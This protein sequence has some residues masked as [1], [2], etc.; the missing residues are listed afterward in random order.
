MAKKPDMNKKCGFCG[1]DG[2][3][4]KQAG[5]YGEW[6]LVDADEKVHECDNPIKRRY[7]KERRK[8]EMMKDFEVQS[9]KLRA[10]DKLFGHARQSKK[11]QEEDVFV[12][13]AS[14]ER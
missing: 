2:F 12:S 6:K 4:W 14:K 13:Y 11:K 5:K 3:H 10:T 1:A 9:S 7:A 8:Y